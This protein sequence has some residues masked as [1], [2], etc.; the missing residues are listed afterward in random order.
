MRL[1]MTALLLAALPLTACNTAAPAAMAEMPA[2][3]S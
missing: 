3:R 1:P 2:S